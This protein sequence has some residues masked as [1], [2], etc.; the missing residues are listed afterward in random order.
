MTFV[1]NILLDTSDI[2]RFIVWILMFLFLVSL[3]FR[4]TIMAASSFLD[5][6]QKVADIA[7]GSR[8]KF[9]K[10]NVACQAGGV[11]SKTRRHGA[12]KTCNTR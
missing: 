12:D 9:S 2:P 1:L 10:M 7:T 5:A 8:G 3:P 6:F 4:Q 11:S